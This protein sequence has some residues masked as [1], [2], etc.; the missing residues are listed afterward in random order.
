M[1][2]GGLCSLSA[3]QDFLEQ[4]VFFDAE[5]WLNDHSVVVDMGS[6]RSL[7]GCCGKGVR[8]IKINSSKS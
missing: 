3:V 5:Q 1:F 2:S 4:P 6:E 7:W 8:C